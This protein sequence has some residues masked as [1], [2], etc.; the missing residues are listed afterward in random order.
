MP[1]GVIDLGPE[2]GDYGGEIVVEGNSKV[3]TVVYGAGVE[4]SGGSLKIQR[5]TEVRVTKGGYSGSR[6]N[7]LGRDRSCPLLTVGR[8][9]L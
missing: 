8:V 5:S 6:H 7:A 3:E 4:G 2:G 9:L 1:I